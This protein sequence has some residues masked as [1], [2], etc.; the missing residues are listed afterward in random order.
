MGDPGGGPG[1][2]SPLLPEDWKVPRA[3]VICLHTLL[4][5][6]RAGTRTQVG[7]PT[8]LMDSTV[9]AVLK[10]HASAGGRALRRIMQPG[11]SVGV[12]RGDAP[13]IPH[14]CGCSSAS[15]LLPGGRGASAF[16]LAPCCPL[17]RPP[18]QG[19]LL[20]NV[21]PSSLPPTLQGRRGPLRGRGWSSPTPQVPGTGRK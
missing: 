15:D 20:Q 2:L 19:V 1:S 6:G 5:N 14:A 16:C 12:P 9:I 8:K 11:L 21:Q 17:S 13:H 4:V 18:S 7:V 3:E 10:T